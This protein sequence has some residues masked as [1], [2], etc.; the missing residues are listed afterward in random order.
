MKALALSLSLSFGRARART[1]TM[2]RSGS[3]LGELAEQWLE[4][5]ATTSE[6]DAI[7][8]NV[9]YQLANLSE[10]VRRGKAKARERARARHETESGASA[11]PTSEDLEERMVRRMVAKALVR[12]EKSA[13]NERQKSQQ[14][15]LDRKDVG[16]ILCGKVEILLA[17]SAQYLEN[18]DDTCCIC[19]EPLKGGVLRLNKCKHH[20]HFL[21]ILKWLELKQVYKCPLCKTDIAD[22]L[23]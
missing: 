17:K 13:H 8:S 1:T 19:L 10:V 20:F 7:T 14:R 11:A 4:H 5:T 21:C 2:E 9:D 12:S 23:S 15:L 22:A 16:T 18:V 6:V 3:G